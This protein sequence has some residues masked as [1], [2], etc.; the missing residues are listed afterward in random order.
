MLRR[1]LI[2]ATAGAIIAI[3]LVA[4][5]EQMAD[6]AIAAGPHLFQPTIAFEYGEAPGANAD[7]GQQYFEARSAPY[8]ASIAYRLTSGQRSDTAKVVITDVQGDTLS[9]L[10]GPGT[11]GL[12]YVTWNFRGK[13]PPSPK[14]S[15]AGVR[16]SIITAR[17]MDQVFD[18]LATAGVA[19]KAAL[20]R[21]HKQLVSGEGFGAFF[22]RSGGPSGQFNPRP[23]ESPAPRSAGAR[24]RRG[25]RGAPGEVPGAQP[26][27]TA[28]ARARRQGGPGGAAGASE[29][30]DRDVLGDI[31]SAL[32]SSGAMTRG[33]GGRG[34]GAALV[35]T[36]DYLVTLTVD[37]KSQQRPLRVVRVSGGSDTSIITGDTEALDP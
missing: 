29:E 35:E 16:D 36:G 18:S 34:R 21:L 37:G 11:P 2:G 30:I 10:T 5:L 9:T 32:R 25:G 20:D 6:S 3:A 19:S 4:V 12:H 15:P 8:G 22:R 1:L 24:G 26:G 23:A 13:A 33:F 17:K 31:F 14:L 7:N 28:N 27:D